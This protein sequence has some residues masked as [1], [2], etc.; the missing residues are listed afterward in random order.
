MYTNGT[1]QRGGKT[2]R[3]HT[4]LKK[5]IREQ[6][7]YKCALCGGYGDQ[8]DHAIPYAISH[9]STLSNLRVLCLPCNLS[10][11]RQRSDAN[12][13]PTI[14]VWFDYLQSELVACS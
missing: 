8:V 14:T 10:L 3:Q 11:R 13:F 1:K 2:Y 7:G 6:A 9:D 12:L 4:S 5:A